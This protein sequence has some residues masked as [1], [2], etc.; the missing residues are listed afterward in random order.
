MAEIKVSLEEMLSDG[1]FRKHLMA[2]IDD[3]RKKGIA[4]TRAKSNPYKSLNQRGLFQ[5]DSIVKSYTDTYFKRSTLPAA[6][7]KAVTILVENAMVKA[8]MEHV[9]N[10]KNNTE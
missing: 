3:V 9:K 8:Y 7:R 5:V 1:I 6:E 2:S 10:R 4:N